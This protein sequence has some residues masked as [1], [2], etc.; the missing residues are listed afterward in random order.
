MI[1]ATVSEKVTLSAA[2]SRPAADTSKPTNMWVMS[3][4]YNEATPQPRVLYND[5]MDPLLAPI[6]DAEHREVGGVKV[7]VSR[8]GSVRVKRM[9]Y[10]PG[11]NWA[12]HLSP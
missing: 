1:G 2:E 9:I 10:P 7:D 4:L 11:F 8:C 3:L 12:E 5:R 6:Q